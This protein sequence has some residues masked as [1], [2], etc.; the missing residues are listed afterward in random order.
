VGGASFEDSEFNRA[1]QARRQVGSTFKPIVYAAAIETE[2]VT[3]ATLVTDG[4]LAFATDQDFIWKPSNYGNDFAGNI[5]LRQALAM[6]KNTCTVRVLDRI[7]P[8]MNDDVIYRFARKLG[9]GGPPTHL[10]PEGHTATPDNDYLCP[11]VRET[12]TST[13]CMDRLPPKD[14][15]LS[16]TAHRARI[17]PDDVYMCRACDL[18][19]GLGSR[20]FTMEEMLRGYSAFPS[21]GK[22]IQP[23]YIEQVRDRNGNVLEQH[24]P[25]EFA[26]V[27]SPEVASITT[28]LLENVVQGGTGSAA[29]RL[30]VHLGGKTGT[31]N[32][33]KDAWFIGFSPDVITGVWVGF[34]QPRPLGVS[35]TGGRTS[36]P[37]WMEYMEAAAP[38]DRDR[39]FRMRGNVEWAQI[40][41]STG[42]RVESGG[43]SYPFLP[44]TAPESTGAVAGQVSIEDIA[45]EL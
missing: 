39:P 9:F 4:P 17:G 5:T 38:R 26:Q 23:Y 13:I 2:K 16:N 36:L 6:S 27:I 33:E 43:R 42:R 20:S 12:P 21:G 30:G 34:D 10:L 32:D 37:I 7:D 29:Q 19:M 22:L 35:S 28:W 40:E 41:E 18:S 3:T 31:T 45:T 8:G 14:P 15:N 44:G 24:Q 1:T 25:Q 11:W